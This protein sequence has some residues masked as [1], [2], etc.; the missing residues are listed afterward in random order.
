MDQKQGDYDE[1]FGFTYKTFNINSL[2]VKRM[3]NEHQK[4]DL[5]GRFALKLTTLP[6]QS[7]ELFDRLG[8]K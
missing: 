1:G 4:N 8:R 7:F 5:E 2:R 6:D 3:S